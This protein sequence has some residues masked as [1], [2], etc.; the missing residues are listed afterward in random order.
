MHISKVHI[1]NFKCFKS[2]FKLNLN[3]GI[4]ILVGDNDTGKSTII[5]AIH[6]ILS[7]LFNGKYLSI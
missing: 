7:G 2:S 1:E 3:N 6:L 5:E 4:N